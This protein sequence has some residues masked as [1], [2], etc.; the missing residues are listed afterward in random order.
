MVGA[1]E[2]YLPLADMVDLD[3]E[4]KPR[5]PKNWRRREAQIERLEQ[6]LAG[7]FADKAPAA[8][9][10][11]ER[12]RL[13]AFKETAGKLRAAIGQVGPQDPAT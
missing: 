11:K 6:L 3:A 7:D 10:A 12:E 4:H 13:A 9:V 2:I 5:S 1:V 8:V